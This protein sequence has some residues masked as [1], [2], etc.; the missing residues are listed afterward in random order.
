M[1]N[2]SLPSQNGWKSLDQ[3]ANPHGE[4]EEVGEASSRTAIDHLEAEVQIKR[5]CGCKGV[6]PLPLELH[7]IDLVVRDQ[8]GR[9]VDVKESTLQGVEMPEVCLHSPKEARKSLTCPW[10]ID[11]PH[12]MLRNAGGNRQGRP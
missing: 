7:T 9:L 3:E 5:L 2:I 8:Q 12:A 4:R 6:I 10:D 1:D 11:L